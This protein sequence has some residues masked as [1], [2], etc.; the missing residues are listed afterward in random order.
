MPETTTRGSLGPMDPLEALSGEPRKPGADETTTA[1][2]AA[3][4][5]TNPTTHDDTPTPDSEAWWSANLI[6]W[7]KAMAAEDAEKWNRNTK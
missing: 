1:P 4:W 6:A 2:D 5:L 3:H 7:G